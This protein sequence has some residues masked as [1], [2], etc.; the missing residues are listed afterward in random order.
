[1]QPRVVH[2][3]LRAAQP[4]MV[5]R[6]NAEQRRLLQA[7]GPPCM[8]RRR[9]R[10]LR[11]RC[12]HNRA[13]VRARLGST[14]WKTGDRKRAQKSVCAGRAN[15]HSCRTSPHRPWRRRPSPAFA[16]AAPPVWPTTVVE[17]RQEGRA[18]VP[19]DQVFGEVALLLGSG[20]SGR[21]RGR[22]RSALSESSGSGAKTKFAIVVGRLV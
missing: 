18:A 11:G 7:H 2:V 14:R 17:A 19:G 13:T 22:R 6:A 5:S 9:W 10:C 16:L 1:M 8:A 20:S 15:L 21:R 3:V 4:A 12:H